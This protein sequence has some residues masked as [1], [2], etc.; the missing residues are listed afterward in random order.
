MNLEAETPPLNRILLVD[1]NAA[2]LE[3]LYQALEDEG[4]ELLVAQ[5]GQEALD[6]TRDAQRN[7]DAYSSVMRGGEV[8]VHDARALLEYCR[9]RDYAIIATFA[10]T[11][12]RRGELLNLRLDDADLAEVPDGA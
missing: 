1:D 11:G 2:N 3:I 6:I 12:I 7:P 5:S 10:F 9:R 8:D 4:Y